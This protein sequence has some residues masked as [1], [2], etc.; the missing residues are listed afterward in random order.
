MSSLNSLTDDQYVYSDSLPD[1]IMLRT[2]SLPRWTAVEQRMPNARP[3]VR[4]LVHRHR[5]VNDGREVI[6]D[7]ITVRA[8]VDNRYGGWY[9]VLSA[10][11]VGEAHPFPYQYSGTHV[12][13]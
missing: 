6:V 7:Y 2:L 1:L 10:Y 4:V 11:C 3:G 13:C 9:H 5:Q 8:P 12:Q